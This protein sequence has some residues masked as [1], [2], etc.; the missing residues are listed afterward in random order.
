MGFWWMT[1]VF[2]AENN[3]TGFS[4]A[5]HF[6]LVHNVTIQCSEISYR[7]EDPQ[8]WCS[9]YLTL[10]TQSILYQHARLFKEAVKGD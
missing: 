4:L 10:L 2:Q 6:A 8:Q 3:L 5:F 9:L 7:A 1:L